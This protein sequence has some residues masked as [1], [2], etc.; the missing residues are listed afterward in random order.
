MRFFDWQ[1]F[2]K[3]NIYEPNKFISDLD[4][5]NSNSNQFQDYKIRLYCFGDCGSK[6][7]KFLLDNTNLK[8]YEYSLP[9][10]RWQDVV[11]GNAPKHFYENL[12]FAQNPREHD[13]YEQFC[14]MFAKH[15]ENKAPRVSMGLRLFSLEITGLY[16]PHELLQFSSDVLFVAD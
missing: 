16:H 15:M 8:V 2:T 3:A 1:S 9:T 4:E 6:I 5:L 10:P 14:T 7:N 13:A 12:S 11:F